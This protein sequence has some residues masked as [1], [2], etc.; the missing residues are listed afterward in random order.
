MYVSKDKL[1]YFEKNLRK[2]YR[3]S[4]QKGQIRIR[5]SYFGSVSDLTKK[6]RVR[7]HNTGSEA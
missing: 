5:S 6:F 3:F 4:C 2:L 1:D 7:I